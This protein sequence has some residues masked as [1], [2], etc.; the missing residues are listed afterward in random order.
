MG[1]NPQFLQ[2]ILAHES[3]NITLDVY[4]QVDLEAVRRAFSKLDFLAEVEDGRSRPREEGRTLDKLRD[5][6]PADRDQALQM[7]ID[8]L[9]GLLPNPSHREDNL[10]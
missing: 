10:R 7:V 3:V 1:L 9:K 2:A 5:S 6:V 8:G 4:A